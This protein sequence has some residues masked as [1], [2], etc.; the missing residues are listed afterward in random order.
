MSERIDLRSDTVTQ[1]T[2]EMRRAAAEA[3]VGDDQ[4]RED[5][6]VNQL[7]QWAAEITGKQAALFVASG[8]M[9]NQLAVLSQTSPGEEVLVEQ[10]AHIFINE[11]AA[12]A[13]VGLVQTRSVAGLRGVLPIQVLG[14]LIRPMDD[15]QPRTGLICIENT[16]NL[17]GGAVL[18]MGYLEEIYAFAG[19]QGIPLHMDGARVFNAAAALNLSVRDIT[20]HCD[21]VTFCLSKGLSA[22]VGSVLCGDRAVIEAARGFRLMLGGAM[23]QSGMLAAAGLVALKTMA[24]RLPEDHRNAKALAEGIAGID[25][26]T[27]YPEDVETNLV[28]FDVRGSGNAPALATALEGKGLLLFDT[29]PDTLRAVTHRHITGEDVKAALAILEETVRD[30]NI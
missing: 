19:E 15:H 22:P 1:P 20:A 25:G 21:T 27:V 6:S 8:I 12:L 9:G 13:R 29:G 16:H 23:R 3:M 7:E 26:L 5:P 2:D 10:Q 28:F 30:L 18:P 11:R 24:H 17:H 14:R 4:L